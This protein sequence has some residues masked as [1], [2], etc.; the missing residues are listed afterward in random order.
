MHNKSAKADFCVCE[1]ANCFACVQNSKAGALSNEHLASETARQACGRGGGS[2]RELWA[3]PN[4]SMR[5]FLGHSFVLS[6]FRYKYLVWAGKE[7]G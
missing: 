6:L 5:T 2:R 4:L 3:R 7:R 1:Q